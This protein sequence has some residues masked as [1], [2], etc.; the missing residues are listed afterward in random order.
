MSEMKTLD[1]YLKQRKGRWYYVRRVPLRYADVDTRRIIKT[2]LKTSSKEVA[3]A[4]RDALAEA[5]DLYWSSLTI[6]SPGSQNG[7]VSRYRAAKAGAFARGY[8]YTPV[9]EMAVQKDMIE[10]I[11]RLRT[12][13][14]SLGTRQ[15][16]VETDALL[17]T[18]P[19]ASIT[20]IPLLFDL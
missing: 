20:I 19:K 10:V 1:Q 7:A 9:E 18:A 3:R 15:E 2:A 5:D 11:D 17:G 4:R 12:L 16:T 13:E 6:G 14:S 8:I